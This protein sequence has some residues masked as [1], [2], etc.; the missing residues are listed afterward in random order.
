MILKI[1][2]LFLSVCSAFALE[3]NPGDEHA[4]LGMGWNETAARHESTD[5]RWMLG[6]EADL[7]VELGE[8]VDR[9][10]SLRCIPCYI[11][12]DKPAEKEWV[13]GVEKSMTQRLALYVNNRFIGE[14]DLD[15]NKVWRFSQPEWNIPAKQ[16]KKG[17]NRITLRS[18]YSKDEK[19]DGEA[20]AV[21]WL[22]IVDQ[23]AGK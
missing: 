2:V 20:I 1:A 7:F 11:V 3:I 13:D 9:H 14:V 4:D 23:N 18:A 19:S 12:L 22:R 21:D 10:V 6:R 15:A 5:Y 8:P 16:W 17:S